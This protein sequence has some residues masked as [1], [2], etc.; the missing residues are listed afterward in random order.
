MNFKKKSYWVKLWLLWFVIG[1]LA[2]LLAYIE[3][4]TMLG[5]LLSV[6]SW[7]PISLILSIIIPEFSS[8]TAALIGLWLCPIV[9][10]LYGLF[11]GLIIDKI[12]SKN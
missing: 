3:G 7:T 1:L 12:K 8:D 9:Y 10:F 5:I 6:G 4:T 11:I 2:L